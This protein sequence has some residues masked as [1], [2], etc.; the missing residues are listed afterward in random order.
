MSDDILDQIYRDILNLQIEQG[1]KTVE[2]LD[3]GSR[4][5]P[6]VYEGM[7]IEEYWIERVYHAHHL[8]EVKNC[9]YRPLWKPSRHL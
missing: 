2:D 6:F 9:T 3:F 7:S 5:Y 8:Q 4:E 1:I